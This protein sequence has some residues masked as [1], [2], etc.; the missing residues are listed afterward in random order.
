MDTIIFDIETTSL[1]HN[2]SEIVEFCCGTINNGEWN[3]LYNSLCS[4]SE[5]ISL[6]AMSVCHIT[7]NMTKGHPSF[8]DQKESIIGVL[9]QHKLKVAHYASYDV[10]VLS[11]HGVELDNVVC[12]FRMT[13]KLFPNLDSYKL[14]Y[15]RYY[16]DLNVPEGIPFHR[17][18][19]DA[20][21]TGVLFDY[22]L[23]VANKQQLFDSEEDLVEWLQ[24][25]IIS[26]TMTFGKY[27]GCKM[28]EVPTDYWMWALN[29]LQTL[30]EDGPDFDRDFA[31]SVEKALE[32]R[33]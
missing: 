17:A 33:I 1:D 27:K 23:D 10:G 13:K 32:G 5:P 6:E 3:E 18:Y 16:F 28:T 9:N 7:N 8:S 25:P 30:Q 26:D 21:V 19:T 11:R 12:T 14:S 22:L 31:A 29:N 24:Q 4:S 2:S 15:L 20:M